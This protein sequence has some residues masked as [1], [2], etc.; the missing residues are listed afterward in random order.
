MVPWVFLDGTYALGWVVRDI[1]EERGLSLER[2]LLDGMS[3]VEDVLWVCED[4][5]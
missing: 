2:G 5:S 4:V 1:V 3:C